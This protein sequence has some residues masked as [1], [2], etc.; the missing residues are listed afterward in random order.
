MYYKITFINNI[1]YTNK[2]PI[3]EFANPR[4]WE[5][6]ILKVQVTKNISEGT[7]RHTWNKTSSIYYRKAI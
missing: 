3:A 2:V 4:K 1:R 6:V 7:F 5:Y